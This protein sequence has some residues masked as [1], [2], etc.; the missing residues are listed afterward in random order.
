MLNIETKLL[1]NE[2]EGSCFLWCFHHSS[3]YLPINYEN[4]NIYCRWFN[5]CPGCIEFN[6]KKKYCKEGI[7]LCVCFTL[8]LE[9]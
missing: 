8:T 3:C 7:Y 9:E 1:P 2:N 5:C 6:M 4:E